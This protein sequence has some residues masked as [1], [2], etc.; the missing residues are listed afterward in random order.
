MGARERL[1]QLRNASDKSQKKIDTH[2]WWLIH[3][4]CAP[5]SHAGG[6]R[7]LRGGWR[8]NGEITELAGEMRPLHNNNQMDKRDFETLQCRTT[9]PLYLNLA[10]RPWAILSLEVAYNNRAAYVFPLCSC[11]QSKQFVDGTNNRVVP[12]SYLMFVH[13]KS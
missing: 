12:T 4:L 10:V 9:L 6:S 3:H 1:C 11:L 7:Y 8:E 2:K 13:P 5:V